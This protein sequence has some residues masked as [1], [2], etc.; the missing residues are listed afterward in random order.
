MKLSIVI[1]LYI[2]NER[3][4]DY[5]EKLLGT[6]P[7]AKGIEVIV[8]DDNSEISPKKDFSF[9]KTQITIHQN[10]EKY[11]GTARNL[12]IQNAKGQWIV[13]ADSDDLFEKTQWGKIFAILESTDA[14]VLYGG[15]TA[16]KEAGTSKRAQGYQTILEYAKED[17]KALIRYHAPWGKIIR[18]S[19]IIKHDI[20]FDSTRVSNDVMFNAR[21]I[22]HAPKI[23][24]IEGEFYKVREHGTSLTKSAEAQSIVQRTNVVFDYN[25]Y[26]RKH[27]FAEYQVE[28]VKQIRHLFP[29]HPIWGIRLMCK[30]ILQ[31]NP[32]L[33]T[34]FTLKMAKL[35][36][37]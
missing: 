10:G 7:D 22:V 11:A 8:V 5:F 30:S 1:P 12:G 20:K 33:P 37:Q 9:T 16:F 28:P 19:F 2:K 3:D 17:S 21:L 35:K 24:F 25:N 29:S 32:T 4:Q 13:F 34:R 36:R 27:G 14:D 26:L 23:D 15:I 6:I 18:K 31:R